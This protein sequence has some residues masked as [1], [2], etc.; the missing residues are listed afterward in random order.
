MNAAP[1]DVGIAL[2]RARPERVSRIAHGGYSSA[3]AEGFRVVAHAQTSF[4]F[5]GNLR[6]V[7]L[8]LVDASRVSLLVSHDRL[9][10]R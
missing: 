1:P 10:L 7:N 2:E 9:L 8:P 4:A 5:S 6:P 3:G